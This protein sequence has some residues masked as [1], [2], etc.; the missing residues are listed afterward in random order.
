MPPTLHT[1][2]ADTEL[3]L[4]PGDVFLAASASPGLFADR[5]HHNNER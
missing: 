1:M 5:A 2:L 3:S 4:E